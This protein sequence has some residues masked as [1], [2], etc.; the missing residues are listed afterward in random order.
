MPLKILI[1]LISLLFCALLGVVRLSIRPIQRIH[2]VW[3]TEV[4]I[5]LVVFAFLNLTAMLLTQIA[6]ALLP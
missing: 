6:R 2:K 1:A 5:G 4:Q 3:M